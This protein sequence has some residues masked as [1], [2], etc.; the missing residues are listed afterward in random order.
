MPAWKVVKT[1]LWSLAA[2]KL[3]SSLTMLGIIIGVA[4]VITMIS[5]G[6]GAQESITS[7]ISSMGSNLLFIRPGAPTQQHV[8]SANAETLNLDDA[9]AVR[10]QVAHVVGVAAEVNRQA[11]VKYM[12]RNRNISIIGTVPEY[13]EVRNSPVERG[14]FLERRDVISESRIAVIGVDVASDLFGARDPVGREIQIRGMNFLVVGLM[15]EKGSTGWSNPD[16]QIFVPL[17]T[18]QRRLFGIEFIHN[19]NVKID[20]EDNITE[21]QAD[22]ER[23][24]R[25]RHHLLTADEPDFNI[26]SQVEVL[27]RMGDM[28]QTFTLLLGGIAGVSLLVG[29]IGIMNI[30]LVSVTE[31]TREI[32]IRKAI[33]AKR[34]DILRQFLIEAVVMSLLGG[35]I[36]IGLGWLGALAFRTYS[37]WNTR[38]SPDSVALAF[39]FSTAVGLFFGIWPATK[40]ARLNPIEALRYE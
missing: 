26:R 6:K 14:R 5:L 38:I 34:G 33:G 17:T 1:A 35:A 30:M 28:V 12:S 22:V 32:G 27:Q 2:N 7:S 25:T 8:R 18:A 15:K 24:L 3:R 11:Q 37:E 36:G 39:A 4:A 10:K 40:A 29:G 21:A 16:D 13:Q 31:R 20:S 19:L 23:L 9:D